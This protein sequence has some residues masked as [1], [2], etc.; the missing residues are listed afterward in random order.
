MARGMAIPVRTTPRGG[1]K[2][3]AGTPYAK[4]AISVGLTPNLSRNPFQTGDGVEVGISERIVFMNNTPGAEGF[5]RRQIVRLFTRL[6]AAEI[7]KLVPGN[8]G[9]RFEVS[10]GGELTAKIRFVELEADAEAEVDA[11][12]RDALRSAPGNVGGRV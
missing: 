6:R 5:A 9:I 11:N 12:L 2:L 1:A 4:Q 7:A 10:A 3:V 8:E